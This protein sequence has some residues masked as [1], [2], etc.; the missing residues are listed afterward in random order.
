MCQ[1]ILCSICLSNFCAALVNFSESVMRNISSVDCSVY[2]TALCTVL[3][4]LNRQYCI[5]LYNQVEHLTH[6]PISLKPLDG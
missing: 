5:V 2:S 1:I 6:H 3:V 4:Q